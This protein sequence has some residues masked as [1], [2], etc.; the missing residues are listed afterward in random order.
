MRESPRVRR[1]RTDHRVMLQLAEDSSI[2]KFKAVGDPPEKYLIRFKGK[3]FWR[4]DNSAEVLIREEH[5]VSIE[6]GASYPRMMPELLW[7][8]PIFVCL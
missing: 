3:G 8:T 5:E 1:L 6:L 7:K 4:K 2:L